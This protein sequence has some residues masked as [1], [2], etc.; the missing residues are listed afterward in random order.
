M[1]FKE[2]IVIFVK[3]LVFTWFLLQLTVILKHN[4]SMRF[5]K[6]P[7]TNKCRAPAADVVICLKNSVGVV[8]FSEILVVRKY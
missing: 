1:L 8:L 4:I 6:I 5:P 3:K 2:N 7:A